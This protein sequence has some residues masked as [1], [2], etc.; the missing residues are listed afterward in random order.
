MTSRQCVSNCGAGF[1]GTDNFHCVSKCGENSSLIDGKCQ[2]ISG[3][4]PSDENYMECKMFV[5]I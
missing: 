5:K 4:M 3:F 1:I 2:C